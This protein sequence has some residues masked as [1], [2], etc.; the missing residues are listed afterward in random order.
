[1]SESSGSAEQN[2]IAINVS[3]I[4]FKIV[5]ELL[6]MLYDTTKRCYN[7]YGERQQWD[8]LWFKYGVDLMISGHIH[9]Y[10]R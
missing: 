4:S 7:F 3:D 6:S 1:M 5:F 10:E 2:T 9:S 8:S